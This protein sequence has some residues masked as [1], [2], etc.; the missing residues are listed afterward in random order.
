MTL[1]PCVADGPIRDGLYY[2]QTILWLLVPFAVLLLFV[3]FKRD[4]G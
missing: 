4:E 3:G 2:M 1:A